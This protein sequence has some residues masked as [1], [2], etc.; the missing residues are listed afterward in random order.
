MQALR[1]QRSAAL[2]LSS[3]WVLLLVWDA[4]SALAAILDVDDALD[5]DGLQGDDDGS[6]R[7]K[8]GTSRRDDD[9]LG[10][11]ERVK[12]ASR[13]QGQALAELLLPN[14]AGKPHQVD[15]AAQASKPFFTE[16][17]LAW[18]DAATRSSVTLDHKVWPALEAQPSSKSWDS[19]LHR[20]HVYVVSLE[21]SADRRPLFA[22]AFRKLGM[23]VEGAYWLPAINGHDVP[24]A[25]R[26]PN[27]ANAHGA[28]K[29]FAEAP[30][31]FGCY[32][33]HLLALRQHMRRCPECDL[34]VFEDDVQFHPQ[35][36]AKM[37]EFTAGLP[38][39]LPAANASGAHEVPVAR[40]HLGGDAFWAPVIKS[41]PTYFQVSW[42]SRTWG[43][44][45]KGREFGSLI[46]QLRDANSDTNMGVD[47]QMS[48]VS[49][50]K[51]FAVLTP[52]RPLVIS[53]P[54]TVSMT[55]AKGGK[56]GS[57]ESIAVDPALWNPKQDCWAATYLPG[58]PCL[59]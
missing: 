27:G 3:A 57:H 53:P 55:A 41:T 40:Y 59:S 20:P 5:S 51:K 13:L 58:T 35:F 49:F 47:Q 16:Q 45:V 39:L 44:A 23:N 1:S 24:V 12:L 37:Q 9:A 54:G 31:V 4:N 11:G 56:S 52:K 8:S 19:G 18:G 28:E 10:A 43:Y 34:V 25:L 33:S 48:G 14:L 22:A 46:E 29:A 30:G 42:V 38:S 26:N 21:Q 32:M 50:V 6:N 7:K 36:K 15:E 2:L 17:L